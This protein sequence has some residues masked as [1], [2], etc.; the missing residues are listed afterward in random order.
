MWCCVR[1]G[2][3]YTVKQGSYV[4]QIRRQ[5]DRVLIEID[6]PWIRP[7]SP[8]MP[9][10]GGIPPTTSERKIWDYFYNYIIGNEKSENEDYTYGQYIVPQVPDVI[11]KLNDS[12]GNTNQAC[13][14]IGDVHSVKLDDPP[15]LR[16]IDFKV[17]VGRLNMSL[18]FRSWDLFT[19]MPENL[20][21]LQLLKEYILSWLNFPVKD[22]KIICYSSG[23]HLYEQYFPLVNTLCVDKIY[24]KEC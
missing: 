2:Y 22:G 9:E 12:K 19:G 17:V 4:G 20:G 1:N 13:V 11:K 3:D 10:G 5:L 15:C 23:L 7:L 14:Q 16:A 6:E 24:I 18:F 21:G 8:R